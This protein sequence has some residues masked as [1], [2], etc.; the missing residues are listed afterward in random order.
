VVETDAMDFRRCLEIQRPY[1]GSVVGVYTDWTP[2]QSQGRLFVTAVDRRDP[3]QFA[4]IL[5]R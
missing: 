2:L 4:N 3:W 1:L 5:V